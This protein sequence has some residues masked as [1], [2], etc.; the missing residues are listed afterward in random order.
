M[1][2]VIVACSSR[3][4]GWLK[5]LSADYDKKISFWLPSNLALLP[6]PSLGREARDKKIQIETESFLKFIKPDDYVVLCDEKGQNL[7]SLLFAKRLEAIMGSGKK[8]VLL[9]IGGAY[10]FGAAVKERAD[11]KLSLSGLTMSHHIALAVIYE[12]IYR[13]LTIIKGTA[14][15]N[16]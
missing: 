13:A 2:L 8:R 9:L 5:E 10:G 12:Q 15:H 11:L 7:S 6:T 16:E 4:P 1:K 14:Y 3:L